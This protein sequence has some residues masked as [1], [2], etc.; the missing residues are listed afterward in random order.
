MAGKSY[1]SLT[2]ENKH[3]WNAKKYNEQYEIGWGNIFKT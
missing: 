1:A 3:L 2:E